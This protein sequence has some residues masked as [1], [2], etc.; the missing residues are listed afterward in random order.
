MYRD[1]V[2]SYNE[3]YAQYYKHAI[4]TDFA[5]DD[6]TWQLIR[7]LLAFRYYILELI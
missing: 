5:G 4:E 6:N 1:V 2:D 3:Q 7:S